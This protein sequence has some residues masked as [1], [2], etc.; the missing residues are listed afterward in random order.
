MNPT[1]WEQAK[2]SVPRCTRCDDWH[3]AGLA[4]RCPSCD[5]EIGEKFDQLVEAEN[6]LKSTGVN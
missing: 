3:K 4:N 2:R 5:H 1:L 6:S